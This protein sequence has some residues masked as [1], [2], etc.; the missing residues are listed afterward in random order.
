M[1]KATLQKLTLA[2][3]TAGFSKVVFAI[4]PL[5]DE[6]AREAVAQASIEV[7]AS[8]YTKID[9]V[10]VRDDIE[11]GVPGDIGGGALLFEDFELG[12]GF[13][14]SDTPFGR[15]NISLA[16][17]VIPVSEL[18]LGMAAIDL[19][20]GDVL[21]Q[22]MSGL[23]ADVKIGAIRLG[24]SGATPSLGQLVI[25]DLKI[26]ESNT[27]LYSIQDTAQIGIDTVINQTIGRVE[28]T[29]IETNGLANPEGGGTLAFN[30]VRMSELNLYGTRLESISAEENPFENS[31]AIKVTM[32]SLDSGFI[33]VGGIQ[34]GSEKDRNS[35]DYYDQQLFG[36]K[37]SGLESNGSELYVYTP[38]LGNG[39]RLSQ[40]LDMRIGALTITGGYDPAVIV[41]R[42]LSANL[43]VA[44]ADLGSYISA[45]EYDINGTPA[46]GVDTEYD[47]LF[48]SV[49]AIEDELT[50][51]DDV[52]TDTLKVRAR[53]LN[54]GYA[55]SVEESGEGG[56]ITLAGIELES[57]ASII[58]IDIDQDDTL[59]IS[60]PLLNG[61]IAVE[62]I[63]IGDNSI[64]SL[65]FDGV[66]IPVN[67]MRITG[68][69]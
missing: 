60:A 44:G 62:D 23:D 53:E 1:D 41:R 10:I 5:S 46:P 50:G 68:K 27:Y 38:S 31:A 8:I 58:S 47:R 63:F 3:L 19:A 32:P 26:D 37:L 48:N 51:L 14:D 16:V 11:P 36:M 52:D 12:N 18:S 15:L 28:Y 2:V 43:E 67:T 6:E 20:Q 59:V 65:I 22:K 40:A 35:A 13:L 55:A 49:A 61:R 45:Q 9:E 57:D 66:N 64:G 24:D 21:S 30:E 42:E 25:E 39:V 69:E 29:D 4:T 17:E 33:S 34:I 7:D 56:T 54:A